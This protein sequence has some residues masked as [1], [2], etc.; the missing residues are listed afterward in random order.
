MDLHSSPQQRRSERFYFAFGSNL[1]LGQMAKRC[2]ESRYI[3]T[4]KLHDYRFQINQRGYANVVSSPGDCV[5]GLIYLLSLTDEARLDK[6]EGVPTAYQK[7]NLVIELFTAAIDHV[8]RAVPELVQQLERSEPCSVPLQ[9][10]TDSMDS[11]RDS[12]SDLHPPISQKRRSWHS[13]PSL[14]RGYTKGHTT[15]QA[16]ADERIETQAE[17]G[18]CR[19]VRDCSLKG[20][21]T[22]ALVYVSKDFVQDDKPRNEYIDRMNAGIVDARKLGMSDMYIGACLRPYIKGRELLN[23]GSTSA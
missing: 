21:A 14:A 19:R 11:C 17:H 1:H 6:S 3:G 16:W 5:E 18:G 12:L 22:E 15:N 9:A 13:G 8:G 10:S 4:A 20:Q 7:R 2:P 23:Q